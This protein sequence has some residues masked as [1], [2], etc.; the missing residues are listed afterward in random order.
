MAMDVYNRGGGGTLRGLEVPG[1]IGLVSLGDFDAD[2]SESYFAQ[3]YVL[4]SGEI[5]IAYRDTDQPMDILA[6][7]LA[8]GAYDIAQAWRAAEFYQVLAAANPSTAISVTG[9]SLGG[10]LAGFVGSVYGL[11]GILFDNMAFELAA[12]NAHYNSTTLVPN[13]S[14]YID[15]DA[16]LNLYDNSPT[17]LDWGSLSGFAVT[18]EF[19]FL[20]RGSQQ[21]PV[22]ALAPHTSELST[23][24]LHNQS[25]LTILLYASD[26][27][28]FAENYDPSKD[29]WHVFG[30]QLI[31]TLY[32]EELAQAVGTQNAAGPERFSR[33]NFTHRTGRYRQQGE[34]RWA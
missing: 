10:G 23:W 18:G 16:R 19:L 27:A 21:T 34:I 1:S 9:H 12:A 26:L 30:N 14:V 32:S 13:T 17:P 25:L 5:V 33:I 24:Q 29:R 7:P 15:P 28:G 20:N 11:D 31:P 4:R 3:S 2:V 8:V 6:Y 22:T